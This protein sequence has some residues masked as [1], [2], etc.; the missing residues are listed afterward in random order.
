MKLM[1]LSSSSDWPEAILLLI[2]IVF[3]GFAGPPALGVLLYLGLA[4][5]FCERWQPVPDD[6]PIERFTYYA[7]ILAV[8]L[9][10]NVSVYV[11]A[12]IIKR[13]IEIVRV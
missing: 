5:S 8:F 13:T 1:P 2:A 10:L 3:L 9:G 12:G 7:R 11:L 6:L 4:W